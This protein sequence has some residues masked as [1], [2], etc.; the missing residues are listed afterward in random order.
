M[1]EGGTEREQRR[2]DRR[3]PRGAAEAWHAAERAAL[4]HLSKAEV[5]RALVDGGRSPESDARSV[6]RLV[7]LLH[8]ASALL[9]D[10]AALPVYRRGQ[11]ERRAL[12]VSEALRRTAQ[13]W[14]VPPADG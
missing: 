13:E 3:Q 4:E 5:L 12:P 14:G 2:T 6:R 8:R 1:G 7:V 11:T 10:A 9:D